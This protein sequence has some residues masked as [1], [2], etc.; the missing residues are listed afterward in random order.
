MQTQLNY[1]FSHLCIAEELK[2]RREMEQM[3]KEITEEVLSRISIRLEDEAI[4]QLR[5]AINSLGK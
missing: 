3:K 4:Q 1:E 5:N 2:R